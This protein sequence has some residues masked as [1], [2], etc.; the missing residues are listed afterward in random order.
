MSGQNER[1]PPATAGARPVG[2]ADVK[3]PPSPGRLDGA[4]MKNDRIYYRWFTTDWF[5][6]RTRAALDPATTA[7]YRDFIDLCMDNGDTGHAQD[8]GKPLSFDDLAYMLTT[9]RHPVEAVRGCLQT[10]LDREAIRHDD[11]GYYNSRCL[12]EAAWRRAQTE[13]ARKA[14]KASGNARSTSVEHMLNTCS[15]HVAPK[16]NQSDPKSKTESKTEVETSDPV[17]SVS[18]PSAGTVCPQKEI[19]AL[20]HSILP[21]RPR[22]AEWTVANATTLRCAWRGKAERQSLEWWTEYFERIARSAFLLGLSHSPG[23]TAFRQGLEWFVRPANMAKVLNGNYDDGGAG[24]RPA[25]SPAAALPSPP[26]AAPEPEPEPTAGELAEE[27]AKAHMIA[28]D[29]GAGRRARE[30]AAKRVDELTCRLATM[31][32]DERVNP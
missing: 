5:G 23:R 19:I 14:G 28:N 10:L 30:A 3:L 1:L 27:I 21:T 31:T 20:Y 6:S 32:T 25:A 24:T 12:V 26:E 15:T 29:N 2:E 13:K 16:L 17:G 7:V 8:G 11:Q 4:R 9:P 22:V 18:P